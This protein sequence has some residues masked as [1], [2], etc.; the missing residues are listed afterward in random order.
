MNPGAKDRIAGMA[1]EAKGKVKE[2]AGQAL[3]NPDVEAE[4]RAENLGGKIQKK[5]G[6]VEQVFEK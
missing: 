4:G 5:V 6:E 3:S 1:H 2:V